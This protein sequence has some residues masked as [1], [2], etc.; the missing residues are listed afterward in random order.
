[1]ALFDGLN[2]PEFEAR[3]PSSVGLRHP[4]S[5]VL[6]DVELEMAFDLRGEVPVAAGSI[7]DADDPGDKDP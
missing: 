6:V 1:M 7:D 2:R 5:H 3:P 4:A